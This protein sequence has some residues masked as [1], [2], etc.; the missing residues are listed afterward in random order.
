MDSIAQSAVAGLIAALAA[1]AIL[2]IARFVRHLWGRHQDV[3][4]IRTLVIEGRERVMGAKD[5]NFRGMNVSMS[6]DAIRAAQYN[7]MLKQIGLALEKWAVM[8]SHAQRKDIYDALDWYHANPEGILAVKR[9]GKLVVVEAPEG[10]WPG[11]EMLLD[12]A[13]ERFKRLG[14]IKWLKLNVD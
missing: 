14:S 3:K 6:A 7:I 8:L 11:N 12:A 1:T 4:Y 10:T 9:D 5:T 13:A 2:G